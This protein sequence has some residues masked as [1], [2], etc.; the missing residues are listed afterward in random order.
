MPGSLAKVIPVTNLVEAKHVREN[1][2]YFP[3]D[4][5]DPNGTFRYIV[6]SSPYQTRKSKTIDSV[7]LLLQP[8]H[9]SAGEPTLPP[10]K[11]KILKEDMAARKAAVRQDLA[12]DL[13]EED[14]DMLL[15]DPTGVMH[16]RQSSEMA[17]LH[18]PLA[19]DR[20]VHRK[21]R[22]H[23]GEVRRIQNRMLIKPEWSG[24]TLD[25]GISDR[26]LATFD[27]M[28]RLNELS[29]AFGVEEQ[30]QQFIRDYLVRPD[31]DE[32]VV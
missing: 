27:V 22:Y 23:A 6:G 13:T 26:T 32:V 18:I 19:I 20:V 21:R 12:R 3:E 28:K 2:L 8:A 15:D 11:T 9:S 17:W 25:A 29:V 24:V 10:G 4:H 31:A 5:T 14:V 16:M 7:E 1:V 30:A